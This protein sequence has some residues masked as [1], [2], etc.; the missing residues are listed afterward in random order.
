[1]LFIVVLILSRSA[2]LLAAAS[3]KHG[4]AVPVPL[5]R[6]L[7]RGF[8]CRGLFTQKGNGCRGRGHLGMPLA[9]MPHLLSRCREDHR[10]LLHTRKAR[11]LSEGRDPCGNSGRL[12]EN[13][14]KA[15]ARRAL[16]T[17]P[18]KRRLPG[19]RHQTPAAQ[20]WF[21]EYGSEAARVMFARKTHLCPEERARRA[22]YQHSRYMHSIM[23]GRKGAGTPS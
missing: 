7:I 2:A 23:C 6:L 13:G 4:L 18:A 21:G 14:S 1:M 9:D 11:R 19:G 17:R 16:S 10:G 12:H 8:T 15:C 5:A 20:G 3:L 22:S